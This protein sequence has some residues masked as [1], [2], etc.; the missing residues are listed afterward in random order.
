HILTGARE[1]LRDF[2]DHAHCAQQNDQAGWVDV[3]SV[4][5]IQP[6]RAKIVQIEDH[7]R[8]A[9]F[10]HN[11]SLSAITNVCAHQGGPLG[12]GKI[13]DGCVT[14]PWHGYQYKPACGQSPPPYTEKIATYDIRVEGRRVLIN[15][16]PNA[17]GTHTEP[18]T[19]EP[20][21]ED[22]HD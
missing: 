11:D 14:C 2:R 22:Q 19:F 3:C 6:D 9:V 4:D 10:R 8:I 5:D 18:A 13:I 12:E 7:E 15:P 1:V 17:A 21:P 16:K 20:W